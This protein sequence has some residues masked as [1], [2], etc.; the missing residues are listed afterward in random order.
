MGDDSGLST[1]ASIIAR[2]LGEGGRQAE[3]RKDASGLGDGVW[4]PGP[5]AGGL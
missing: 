4:G 2:I 1:W 5:R 3:K